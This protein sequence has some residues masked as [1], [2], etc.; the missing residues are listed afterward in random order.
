MA[1][2]EERKR[3]NGKS[4]WRVRIRVKGSETIT[5]TFERKTDATEWACREEAKI[6]EGINFPKRKL[7]N[8]TVGEIIDQFMDLKLNQYKPKMQTELKKHLAWWKEEIGK[9]Y[10]SSI[11]TATLVECRDKLAKKEKE[12]PT[13]NGK[14]IIKEGETLSHTTVNHYLASINTVFSYCIKDLD[15][16]DINPMSKVEKLK[17]NNARK[18]FLDKKEITKLLNACKEESHD[19]YLCVLIALLSGARKSEILNLTWACVDFEHGFLTFLNTK[20]GE[21]R[22][23]PMHEFLCNELKE[24]RNNSKIRHL[25]SDHLFTT[26]TG[27]INEPLIGKLFPKI[28][29]KIGIENFRFHDLRHTQASYQAM[30]GVSQVMTQKTLGH[31]TSE[32]TNRYSHLRADVLRPTINTVG[33][34]MLEEWLEHDNNE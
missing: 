33:N 14:T 30:S 19:L 20:N 9:L 1:T 18:R 32:M 8:L 4:N 21:D 6:K 15:I 3:K 2:I 22:G 28:V 25:K 11:T 24:F 16:I 26:P 10:L 5:K 13:N 12:V 34:T 7:K 29:K 17:I 23:T 31:K 27:K